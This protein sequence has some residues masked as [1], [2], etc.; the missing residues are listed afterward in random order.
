MR[1]LS[2]LDSPN[3][4]RGNGVGMSILALPFDLRLWTGV[5]EPARYQ[6]EV[7]LRFTERR[8]LIQ[9]LN[10]VLTES[11]VRSC[12]L[13]IPLTQ[14][15]FEQL[16]TTPPWSEIQRG[17]HL[18]RLKRDVLALLLNKQDAV[19]LTLYLD[20]GEVVHT[21]TWLSPEGFCL[22]DLVAMW[23]GW[24]E[25]VGLCTFEEAVRARGYPD[26]VSI[27]D[28]RIVTSFCDASGAVIAR[29]PLV[30]GP[31]DKRTV[32][33]LS[34]TDTWSWQRMVRTAIW[35]DDKLPFGPVGY[36]PP[37]GWQAGER[38]SRYGYRDRF[39]GVWDW[40]GRRAIDAR[41]PFGGHWNVQLPDGQ[42][43]RRWV[44]WIE[45]CLGREI[46]T[47]PD[48]ITHI[49]VEPD[50]HIADLTFTWRT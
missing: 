24:V 20:V 32:P 29:Q 4:R 1:L 21:H 10:Q 33:L 15:L 16:T 36:C 7:Y 14:R 8:D 6:T 44:D 17:T 28:C 40:E 35:Q 46:V 30:D 48:A 39:G 41:N 9:Q 42:A 50:G 47:H 3:S 19:A 26:L 22:P 31:E 5:D 11:A 45:R 27:L 37:E 23:Q 34:Q 18:H 38:P 2:G 49:N 12:R 25:T 13:R 43:R